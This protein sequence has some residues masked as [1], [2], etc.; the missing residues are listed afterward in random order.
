MHALW[1][2]LQLTEHSQPLAEFGTAVHVEASQLC[3]AAI[4]TMIGNGH[5]AL[6]GEDRW[7][8]GYRIQEVAPNIYAQ[9]R[10]ATR[11]T[12]TV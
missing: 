2:R 10:R 7:L 1:S 6:F 3:K 9:V 12:R 4:K 8:Q 5:T 11:A